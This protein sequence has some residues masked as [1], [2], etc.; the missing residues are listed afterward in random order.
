MTVGAGLLAS[1]LLT[2]V[3]GTDAS[4]S[5]D[6]TPTWLWWL[7]I[8]VL[9]SRDTVPLVV[10]AAVVAVLV[11][12]LAGAMA[13]WSLSAG[14][15]V[16]AALGL[17]GAWEIWSTDSGLLVVLIPLSAC[18]LGMVV[19]AILGTIGRSRRP[20]RHAR[21]TAAPAGAVSRRRALALAA[22]AA[23]A[24]VAAGSAGLLMGSTGPAPRRVIGARKPT[25][26]ALLRGQVVDV[27]A[28]GA[29]GD[30]R[31]DDSA[32]LLGAL[33]TVNRAG[34]TLYLPAGTYL[35]GS[36]TPLSPAAGV[37]ISGVPGS[38]IIDFAPKDAGAFAFGCAIEAHDVTIDGL[39]LRRGAAVDSVLIGTGSF[40]RFTLSR[41]MLVGS[42]DRFPNSYCHGI[43]FSDIGNAAAFHMVDSTITT[44][45]YG[46]FQTNQSTTVTTDVLVERCSFSANRNTDL[47]FNSPNGVTRRLRVQDCAFSDN[48]SPGF[49][50]GLANVQNAVISGNTFDNYAME[51]VH[52]EDYSA[53]V[54]VA[55]NQFS[56]C[57]LRKHSNVQ[58]LS[59]A[60]DVQVVDNTF[61]TAANTTDIYVVTAQPG[62]VG[63]TGGGRQIIPPTGVSVRNNRISCSESVTPVYFEGT[64]G[65]QI[66]GNTITGPPSLTGPDTAF[67]VV[68]VSGDIA[69]DN[70][71]NGRHF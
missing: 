67:T 33:A 23:V 53:T 19:L 27:R 45:Q 54:S 63:L 50:V 42:M 37:T 8:T 20:P 36:S 59:G 46:L 2:P 21:G 25:G 28:L 11:G 7:S 66:A 40:Q 41:S 32:V 61:D 65:G 29:V 69:V 12:M 31:T 14:L 68:G 48:D 71:I 26:T 52:I 39:V 43:K 55:G 47:E 60:R 30:G 62:G 1:R 57:G 13:R 4:I 10:G 15:A 18:G 5:V 16:M 17:L 9:G 70:Q 22:V 58:V 34:G 64:T 51:A 49:G 44:T 3:R 6:G 56:N 35:F 38:S 24:A